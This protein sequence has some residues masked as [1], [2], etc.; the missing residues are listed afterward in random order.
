[1]KRTWTIIGV[2]DVARSL[3][4]YQSLFGQ[5]A[6]PPGHDFE[7]KSGSGELGLYQPKHPLAIRPRRSA[8]RTGANGARCARHRK[9]R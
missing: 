6:T 7:W 1:M 2:T 5:P 3:H 9:V 4:W 8:T